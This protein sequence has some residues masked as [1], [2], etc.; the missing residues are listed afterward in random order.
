MQRIVCVYLKYIALVIKEKVL[1]FWYLY[2]TVGIDCEN[3][4]MNGLVGD[5]VKEEM[6]YAFVPDF[7][8]NKRSGKLLYWK[9]VVHR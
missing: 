4:N 5:G 3:G 6:N 2:W 1:A 9:G 7:N 8:E